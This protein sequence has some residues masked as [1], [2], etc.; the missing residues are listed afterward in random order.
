MTFPSPWGCNFPGLIKFFH[1]L[2]RNN[3]PQKEEGK[4]TE[5]NS[6]EQK[7]LL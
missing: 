6:T 4:G 1:P 3:F 5:T 2:F 7:A